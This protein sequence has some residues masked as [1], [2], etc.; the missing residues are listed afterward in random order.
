MHKDENA[1]WGN[2]TNV[3]FFFAKDINVLS[4]CAEGTFHNYV[5][6]VNALIIKVEIRKATR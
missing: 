6:H 5:L 4:N 2:N 1:D 3:L